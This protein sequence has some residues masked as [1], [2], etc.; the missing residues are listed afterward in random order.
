MGLFSSFYDYLK[1]KEKKEL[2]EKICKNNS[3]KLDYKTNEDSVIILKEI[4][5]ERVYAD[6]FPFY[7]NSV[8]VDIGAH[9]GY[10][11]LFAAKNLNSKSRIIAYEPFKNNYQIML[12]NIKLND[13]ENINIFNKGIYSQAKEQEIYLSKSENNS[14]FKEY[15]SYLKQDYQDI[16]KAS[17]IRLADIFIENKIEQIDY[18]K[19]DV[20]GAEYDILFDTEPEVLNKI[21]V[22]S[23]EFHD[24][25][26][27]EYTGIKLVEFLKRN[28]FE[29][30]KFQHE[31]TVIDNNFGK[32]VAVNIY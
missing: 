7:S 4:F 21:K 2:F 24:L 18:L 8:I 22:I 20:E 5:I 9:K 12:E 3:I 16:E 25:K 28:N 30:I 29:I 14:L 31:A 32:I 13:I 11:S 10:F 17:F 1:D 27:E 15:N 26:K 19:L 6:Y 23:M